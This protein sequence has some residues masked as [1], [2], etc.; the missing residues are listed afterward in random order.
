MKFKNIRVQVTT[1]LEI[2]KISG[3][4]AEFPDFDFKI[5]MFFENK[6]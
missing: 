3:S 6:L 4:R 2:L 5:I 1:F